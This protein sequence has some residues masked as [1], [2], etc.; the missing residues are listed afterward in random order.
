MIYEIILK[1]SGVRMGII[2]ISAY[3]VS[4]VGSE[5]LE[6]VIEKNVEKKGGLSARKRSD[7]LERTFSNAFSVLI[8]VT[9]VF[10]ALSEL[11][12]NLGPLLAGA[13]VFG[14]AVGFGAQYM[15]RDFLA[16]FFI[17]LENQYRVGDVVCIEDQCGE[18]EDIT[19]RK[20]VLRDP[21]GVVHHIPNGE[22]KKASNMTQD[23]AR[24]NVNIG[25]AYEEDLDRVINVINKVGE[26]M[27]KEKEWEGKIID[28]PHFFRLESLGDS[29]VVMTIRVETE[30]LF[31]WD[32]ESELK[33]RIKETFEKEGIEMPYPQMEIR[34]KN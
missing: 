9:A 29:S 17:I 10:V 31:R 11:G 27:A 25:V 30:P 32:A 13:G 21:D 16:G 33:K 34:R 20:T 24:V 15:V 8:W 12:V 6:K 1:N 19:F 4:K 14:V 5:L 23:F 26:K 28:P 3:F 18:V 2:I 7:T 22:V